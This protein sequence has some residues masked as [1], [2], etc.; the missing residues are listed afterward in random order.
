MYTL[1][2]PFYA[3]QL[4]GRTLAPNQ[5]IQRRRKDGREKHG[6]AR[7]CCRFHKLLDQR[8]V[9]FA[10]HRHIKTGCDA[11][12]MEPL[13]INEIVLGDHRLFDLQDDL[14][15]LGLRSLLRFDEN[16]NG[17]FARFHVPGQIKG[18]ADRGVSVSFTGDIIRFG[19]GI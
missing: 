2:P 5:R 17:M 15:G 16:R 6:D 9:F 19:N 8:P 14:Y 3:D 4:H 13:C 7:S 11:V 10:H 18:D 12:A 1:P